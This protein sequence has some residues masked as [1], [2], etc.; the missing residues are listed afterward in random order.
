[1]TRRPVALVTGVVLMAE[2]V[3]IAWLH[4]FLGVVVDNQRMSLAGLDPDHMSLGT[5]GMGA[6]LGLFLLFCGFVL[7]RS[8][9]RD[10]V[11]GRFSR[12]VLIAC[13]VGHAVLGAV[14][15][16]LVG[17]GSFAFLMLV[18]GLIVLSLIIYGD[19]AGGPRRGGSAHAGGGTE[20][21]SGKP[22][23]GDT[24]PPPV[25]PGNSPA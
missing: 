5:R 7:L 2:A 16:G 11:P 8:G 4:W 3:G 15:V 21:G 17:W 12:T 9:L 20:P 25:T 19:G 13:A 1:M 6:G 24:T 23:G 10:R 22:S 18:F 14:T